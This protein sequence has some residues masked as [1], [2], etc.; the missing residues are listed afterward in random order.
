MTPPVNSGTT[1]LR[2]TAVEE[3]RNVIY[4]ETNFV[5]TWI[6]AANRLIRMGRANK[7]ATTIRAAY[8]DLTKPEGIAFANKFSSLKDVT[9]VIVLYRKDPQ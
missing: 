9:S 4:L 6:V 2:R 3:G 7:Y 1:T 8:I 5:P